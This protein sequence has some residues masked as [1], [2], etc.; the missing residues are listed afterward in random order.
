MRAA[1][2]DPEKA[3]IRRAKMSAAA[4]ARWAARKAAKEA[5]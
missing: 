3:A 2:A 1:W 5:E 4:K